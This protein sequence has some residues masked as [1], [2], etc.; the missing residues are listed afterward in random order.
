MVSSALGKKKK[1]HVWQPTNNKPVEVSDFF[2]KN[3]MT[4]K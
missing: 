4:P 2:H 1:G 3:E